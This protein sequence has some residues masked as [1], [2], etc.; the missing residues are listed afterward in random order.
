MKTLKG[1]VKINLKESKTAYL[2]IGILFLANII[3]EIITRVI[4][5]LG[6]GGLAA[7]NYLI[8]LPLLMGIFIPAKNFS[9][10]LNLG[11]KRWDFFRGCLFSYLIA[12]FF[13]TLVCLALWLILDPLLL[14]FSSDLSLY[15][16]FEVFGF[17][18]NGLAVAFTQMFAFLFLTS[19]AA[20][21]LTMIQGHWYGWLTDALIIAIISV[22]TPIAPL[23]AGLVW[24][25][26]M[27]IFHN[28]AAAQILSC[29]ILALIVYCAALVPIKTK[30]I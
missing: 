10:L 15:N 19:C 8:I 28:L 6:G 22:F 29:L 23:R 21:T 26:K 4:M 25:F 13:T 14:P 27:I 2:I 1:V 12:A 9:K 11:C 20:H 24:F 3:S 5:H 16:L 30:Q 18:K 17:A 7:G